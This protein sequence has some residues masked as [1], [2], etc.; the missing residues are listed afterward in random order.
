MPYP[1]QGAALGR[2]T[3]GQA[4]H[5]EE[6]FDEGFDLEFGGNFPEDADLSFGGNEGLHYAGLPA[7]AFGGSNARPREFVQGSQEPGWAV[8]GPET[9][10][11]EFFQ[12]PQEL[13]WAPANFITWQNVPSPSQLIQ[14]LPVFPEPGFAY[15]GAVPPP[16][17]T[18][19]HTRNTSFSSDGPG[20][21]LRS[22]EPGMGYEFNNLPQTR[23]DNWQTQIGGYHHDETEALRDHFAELDA[24][25][26]PGYGRR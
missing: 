18:L 6:G 11:N 26:A 2:L 5:A 7:L 24:M 22:Y 14:L 10:Q 12:N 17:E 3:E 25:A 1:E 21:L 15:G 16:N 4:R 8:A 13:D 20:V 9:R 23:P 19:T